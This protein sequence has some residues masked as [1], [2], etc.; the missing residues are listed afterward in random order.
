MSTARE[1]CQAVAPP[2]IP[3]GED[4]FVDDSGTTLRWLGMAGFLLNARGTTILIDPV[5][6]SFDM[7]LLVDIPLRVA[8]VL[9]VDAVLVTHGDN[10]HFSVPT[11][12]ELAP[13][14]AAFHTTRYVASVMADEGVPGTG[15]DIG[16]DFSVGGQVR[17]TVLPADHAWQNAQPGYHGRRFADEDSC[18][19]WVETVDGVV[20][21]PGDS[22]LIR[23]HHLTRPAPDV[24]L[25]DFSDSEWHFGLDGAVEMANAYPRADLVL[26]HW[27][28]VDSPEFAPFN[29][30]PAVLWSRI[31][32]P[33]RIRVVAPG[34]AFTV[35]S[36]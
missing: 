10:D 11:C 18:G 16:D 25:F 6:H 22:R 20:W 27:G 4:A 21:A 35:R 32:N 36:R 12:R 2:S 34:E 14:T 33:S 8:D 3:I 13:V 30:D 23:A 19:F 28:S 26:H 15:H 24:L 29:G 31:V 5:L 1:P 9:R 7:P 17:V